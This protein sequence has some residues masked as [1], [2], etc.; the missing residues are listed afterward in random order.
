MT[1][2]NE[3]VTVTASA[4]KYNNATDTMVIWD[5][6]Y[7]PPSTK[8]KGSDGGGCLP[9]AGAGLATTLAALTALLA[10]RRRND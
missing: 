1:D 9:G 3:T 10:A 7:V 6:D 4:S 2:A 5:I 8:K